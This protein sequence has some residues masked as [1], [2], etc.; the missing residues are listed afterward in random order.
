[1]SIRG[2]TALVTVW[3]SSLGLSVWTLCACNIGSEAGLPAEMQTQLPTRLPTCAELGTNPGYG[4]VG[5]PQ[6]SS[7]SSSLVPAVMNGVASC[8]VNITVSS[9]FR[10][11]R[12]V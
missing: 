5:H 10:R 6:L 8:Q 9:A 4:L 12:K 11:N 2:E 1:M 7:V 3:I